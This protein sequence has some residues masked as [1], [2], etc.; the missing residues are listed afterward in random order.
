MATTL[1]QIAS[2]LIAKA[3]STG[4]KLSLDN[5]I[6]LSDCFASVLQVLALPQ[7]LFVQV[8]A[9][10]PATNIY[11]AAGTLFVKGV[12]AA[13]GGSLPDF[14]L[15]LVGE[16][17]ATRTAAV[18]GTLSALNL[19]QLAADQLVSNAS[20]ATLLPSLPF[21]DL[22]LDAQSDPTGASGPL[23]TLS[24]ASSPNTWPLLPDLGIDLTGVGVTLRRTAI[25]Q[26]LSVTGAFLLN[27]KPLNVSL[28]VPASSFVVP[29]WTIGLDG[30]GSTI[31]DLA[32]L[33]ALLAGV[34]IFEQ[35]PPGFA[36]IGN[37]G[38]KSL[39]VSFT[40]TSLS[41]SSVQ[42]IMVDVG[43]PA[44]AALPLAGSVAIQQAG[45]QLTILNPFVGANR[46]T[47]AVVYGSLKLGSSS[48]I[49]VTMTIP[50]G[51]SDWVLNAAGQFNLS[52]L[53]VFESLPGGYS[54]SS[55]NLPATVSGAALVLNYFTISFNP[56]SLQLSFIT[57]SAQLQTTWWIID[58]E[59]GFS[60]P[61]LTVYIPGASLKSAPPLSASASGLVLL[62]DNVVLAL[63]A[64]YTKGGPWSFA[65]ALAPG[66]Q[67]NVISLAKYLLQTDVNPA[68]IL[69]INDLL[70][71]AFA[72]SVTSDPATGK[73]TYALSGTTTAN[74][75]LTFGL[76]P[77]IDLVADLAVQYD[78]TTT[79]VAL[80]VSLDLFGVAFKVSYLLQNNTTQLQLAWQGFTFTYDETKNL[81]TAQ[82]GDW[83]LG[84]ILTALVNEID[85]G[86][87]FT[88]P[89]PWS[90]LN[91]ISLKG[92]TLTIDLSTKQVT[93]SYPISVKLFFID[94]TSINLSVENGSGVIVALEGTYLDGQKIPS[95]NAVK[96]SPPAV[97]GSGS[98]MFDL[99]FAAFG[100]HVRLAGLPQPA[101]VQDAI[102]DYTTYLKP[103]NQQSTTVPVVAG[104]SQ[105]TG[106]LVF[107]E[108][109][110]WMLA[111]DFTVAKFYTVQFVFN[112]P[113][114]YGLRI[115][116]AKTAD[117]FGNL[118]F[119]IMYKKIS[120]TIGMYQADLQLP[121]EFRHLEFGEVS[122]T[123]P[124]I[125]I[126]VYT[127]G[128]FYLDFGFPAS[129][130]DFSRSFS[131]QV[132]PFVGYGGFYFGYLSGATS[133]NVPTT[134]YG[135]FNPVIEAGLGLSLGVGK[136]INEGIFS[137]G[138]S[139]TAVG[140]FQG[141]LGFYT[142]YADSSQ[143]DTYY[144]F[145]A[146]VALVG[147]IYGSINFAI[148]SA[149][150]DITA[151]VSLM[152]TIEAYMPIPI[153]FQ[154]GVSVSLTVKINLGLFKISISLRFSITISASF[155]IGTDTSSQAL[156]NRA[157]TTGGA[158]RAAP[159]ALSAPADPV[160]LVWQPLLMAAGQQEPLG[161]YF[162]PHLTVSAAAGPQQAEYVAML[163]IDAPDPAGTSA[164][165]SSLGNLA[166]GVLAWVLNA[167]LNSGSTGTTYASLLTQ[168]V[169]ADDLSL[170]LCVFENQ[171]DSV[172][173]FNYA[174]AAHHDASTFLQQFFSVNIVP[175]PA[176]SAT[177]PVLHAAVFP[178]F[179]ELQLQTVYNGTASAVTDFA[180]QSM[181]GDQGYIAAVTALLQTLGVNYET[182][183]A[184]GQDAASCANVDN[185]GT[186]AQPNLSLP[187]FFI[188]DYL[189]LLA[190]S[191]LQNGLSYF[192]AN[193]TASAT[194]QQVLTGVRTPANIAGLSGMASRFLLHGLRLPA[195]P[196][197]ATGLVQ[198]FYALTGQQ[199]PLPATLATTDTYTIQLLKAA[200]TTW[201]GFNA[202]AATTL[203]ITLAADEITRIIQT[204]GVTIAPTFLPGFPAAMVN[205]A[206]NPQAFTLGSPALW[207][208]PGQYFGGVGT[209]P[210]V[211]KLPANLQNELTLLAG[212]NLD[213]TLMALSAA[214]ENPRPAAV[215]N[216]AWATAVTVTI[217]KITAVEGQPAPL[218]GNM[219]N[220]IGTDDVGV[221]YLQDLVSYLDS[222]AGNTL[223]GTVQVLYQPDPTGNSAGGYISAA[224]NTATPP[225]QIA[226][227][228]IQANLST[229]TNPET[230]GLLRDVLAAA[231][232]FPNT[233]NSFTE[234]VTL[235]WECSIVRSGGYYFYYDA[236]A[237]G[238]AGLP[239]ALF[240]ANGAATVQVLITYPQFLAQ[241]FI[242]SAVVGD[243]LDYSSTAVFAQTPALTVRT[244]TLQPGS[245]GYVIQRHNP[246]D[247]DPATL[248]PTPQEDEVYL[249]NQFNLVGA[250][251]PAVPAY[252]NLLPSGPVDEL[253]PAT[254]VVSGSDAVW[255]Y[256]GIIPYAQFVQPGSPLYGFID[257]YAGVGT[258]VAIQLN[259]Q[260][261][262]GNVL[263]F[264][265]GQGLVNAPLLYT[266]PL[267]AVSQWPSASVG[268]AFAGTSASPEVQLTFGFATAR[269]LGQSAANNAAIDLQTWMR[270]W[271]Q[272]QHAA[273][274]SM[275]FTV[276]IDGT[277]A[278]PL[279]SVRPL[280]LGALQ[281]QFVRP[282]IDYLYG[283]AYPAP[284]LSPAVPPAYVVTS[285]VAPASISS[286]L[287]F[288]ALTVSITMSRTGHVDPNF[289]TTPGVSSAVT[290]VQPLTSA[291]GS[292]ATAIT[293]FATAF[294]ALFNAAGPVYLKVATATN[295]STATTTASATPPLWVVRF[296]T[297]G[298]AGISIPYGQDAD[299]NALA[300]YYAPIPL[301]TSLQSFSAPVPGYQT[302]QPYPGTAAT[303]NFTGIDLDNWGQQFLEALDRFLTP[304]YAVPAFLLDNGTS[305]QL[306]LDAK[307]AL[308]EAIT[309]TVDNII[310]SDV[311]A[312]QANVRNAQEKWLQQLL[313]QLG[314][315][316]AY[317]AAVQTP[318]TVS[319]SWSGPN[320][321]PP[322]AGSPPRLYGQLV[323]APLGNDAGGVFEQEFSLTTAKLP[324]GTGDSWLTYLFQC[325]DAA[326]FASFPFGGMQFAITH[327]EWNYEAVEGVEGYLGSSWLALVLPGA[328]PA[329]FTNVGPVTVPVPLRAYPTP[330]SVTA[331]SAVNPS[332]EATPANAVLAARSW[333]YQFSYQASNVNQDTV[334]VQVQ[335]NVGTAS[336]NG[337]TLGTNP[338]LPLAQALAQFMGVYPAIS[339]D[340]DQHLTQVTTAAASGPAW[341]ALQAFILLAQ[342]VATAWATTNQVNPLKAGPQLRAT[343]PAA[344]T[345]VKLDFQVEESSLKENPQNPLLVTVSAAAAN[346][347][348]LLLGLDIPGYTRAS[349]GSGAGWVQYSYTDPAGQPLLFANRNLVPT[350]LATAPAVDILNQQNGWAGLRI[351]RN[352]DLLQVPGSPTD[353][354]PTNPLFIYQT[355]LVM[356]FSQLAPLFAG[357]APINLAQLP[358]AGGGAAQPRSLADNVLALVAALTQAVTVSSLTAKVECEYAYTLP[359]GLP[360][361]LPVL[362]ALP[363]PLPTADP[364]NAFATTLTAALTAW[365]EQHQPNPTGGQWLFD[366]SLFSAYGSGP[367]M[368]R[369]AFELL[370]AD[371]G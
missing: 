187:T 201:L 57:F 240:D 349:A 170:L 213:F 19:N 336:A 291:A 217:Q 53:S 359:S 237:Q 2:Q 244:A 91:S 4:G 287:D 115:A 259:W 65:A 85:P 239:D 316:Y 265:A 195:P 28:T 145:Q 122:I 185:S 224:N 232:V 34:N 71:T 14:E 337:L 302:G 59:L 208:Y 9:T 273:D 105:P 94:I 252:Q 370:L 161:L 228:I 261:M 245:V 39:L 45:V 317:T 180:Q 329:S 140:I 294:E 251:L 345:F 204:A 222:P 125:G 181:T 162:M 371:L 255:A 166:T 95:W 56:S 151:Y 42:Q 357:T 129:M 83:T 270:L 130:T 353:W 50:F 54:T 98:D 262:F 233:L 109:S 339:A 103:P 366:I 361:T 241:P 107:D 315:A 41:A 286:Y 117:F 297:S 176:G 77:P 154:A 24:L 220:L 1:E 132:F 368:L 17:E 296:D 73:T 342:N 92:L 32:D 219:Y 60:N 301:A 44:T 164:D 179:P 138:L 27:H 86:L 36:A 312:K 99:R 309:G 203:P 335:F 97:P 310:D 143:T 306:I 165:T 303:N 40:P 135:Q 120:D 38:L 173:P 64:S 253:D 346:P 327:V 75:N 293:A 127:N 194:V 280:D 26:T 304:A 141:V 235:L 308:A 108:T 136:T 116:I 298:Q 313:I 234:F 87:N 6:I 150:F 324:I 52:N 61:A 332:P 197:A 10:T 263:P 157:C 289:A 229:D 299:G 149:Q 212:Q 207:Q 183:L 257:P 347:L 274:L 223:A 364:T 188:T 275:A 196:V 55:M 13:Y 5:S 110:S 271:Y 126:K 177:D 159:L 112:D 277:A 290:G 365:Q 247:Y 22:A 139:L 260:D 31:I 169:T 214:G 285:P 323:G 328:L 79:N 340:F 351:I 172:P 11:V 37:F 8:D 158:L 48:Y 344:P 326:D 123:L 210:S 348:P 264:A 78:G 242:N 23:M 341:Q 82:G 288:F 63:G 121:D 70:I 266:D 49:D 243:A 267:L 192:K 74:W 131:V 367:P 153:T 198:P 29:V 350:R 363:F 18:T 190:K 215:Q 128:N 156:W 133:T 279:G 216:Y 93:V 314:G 272:L 248:P 100:Q 362:L 283:I 211:L 12:G 163:Y 174:N 231:P 319:S 305:L 254:G 356:F 102:N 318:V 66:S 76:L 119:E 191:M 7:G 155:T 338:I 124:V 167:L 111:A 134:S 25:A 80:G 343:P 186:Q 331:Q 90:L 88:L 246:G 238:H 171:P 249:E 20:L 250:T 96:D 152:L 168:T 104:S 300:A 69:G 137:A 193:G 81:I 358:A 62:P 230:T 146:T 51:G 322:V 16:D 369:L 58:N 148:I 281:T 33:S 175:P 144:R 360:V 284:S 269:Y 113:S 68:A 334:A 292:S 118:D 21:T 295:L 89:D 178:P 311:A 15:Q 354:Q 330:P 268:Y 355:P 256:S 205:F 218:Q 321:D 43:T 147:R 46:Q 320:T 225:D 114:L 47:T 67:V 35:L 106:T 227:A 325:R 352:Q 276:S 182:A 101:T 226:L 84:G 221:S 206:D 333:D 307:Q 189:A 72:M 236:V 282:A 142:C 202:T 3:Q 209:K 184:A 30:G 278:A 160:A 200:G 258:T 199:V